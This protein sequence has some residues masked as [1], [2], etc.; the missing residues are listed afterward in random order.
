MFAL[1]LNSSFVDARVGFLNNRGNLDG[2][3]W[4][5][6][7]KREVDWNRACGTTFCLWTG[8]RRRCFRRGP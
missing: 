8:T 3:L 7:E 5:S 1:C 2:L 6:K 4:E